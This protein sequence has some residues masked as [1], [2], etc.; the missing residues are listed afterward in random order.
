M[1]REPL[2]LS[3]AEPGTEGCESRLR[4]VT[5]ITGTLP[6]RLLALTLFVLP[7]LLGCAMCANPY[8]Y[9]GPT[10]TGGACDSC[11]GD[12]R[13]ASIFSDGVPQYGETKPIEPRTFKASEEPEEAL[14]PPGEG[15]PESPET[16]PTPPLPKPERADDSAG[17]LNT[18]RRY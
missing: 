14:P 10:F 11:F 5:H 4:S 18:R 16:L 6:L 7:S 2:R 17:R 13:V 15:P 1:K 3:H 12:E 9:C 8:D